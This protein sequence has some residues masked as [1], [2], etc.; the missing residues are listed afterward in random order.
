MERP[1]TYKYAY[2][3]SCTLIRMFTRDDGWELMQRIVDA[4]ERSILTLYT[5]PLSMVEVLGQS[6]GATF[7][8]ALEARVR[9]QLDSNAT[10]P[11]EFEMVVAEKAREI[12]FDH[13]LKTCDAIHLASAAIARAE[14]F[15]TYDVGIS[16]I[17]TYNDV[18]IGEP[19]A[20]DLPP[21]LEAEPD[22]LF[23]KDST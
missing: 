18:W 19:Y 16:R 9:A 23:F 21:S 22:T 7:D 1:N 12:V 4:G 6:P 5:S 13:G 10:M 2:L 17:G 8:P 20:W 14:V 3:D 15:F 11:I